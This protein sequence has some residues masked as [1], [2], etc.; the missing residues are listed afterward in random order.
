MAVLP[1]SLD[2]LYYNGILDH[3]PYEVYD[4]SAYSAAPMVT[5]TAPYPYDS[6]EPINPYRPLVE[7][8]R[9][10]NPKK[11]N[12]SVLIKGIVTAGII[13]GTGAALIHGIKKSGFLK[14]LN[15][16]NWFRKNK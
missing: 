6:F 16:K 4:Y 14:K 12:K 1:G 3:I 11:T 5:V 8:S 7:A 15:P 9:E 13:L 10:E 2:Y